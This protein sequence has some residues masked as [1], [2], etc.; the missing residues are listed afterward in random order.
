MQ[1]TQNAYL[2]TLE[3]LCEK[4]QDNRS[5]SSKREMWS[6]NESGWVATNIIQSLE[7]VIKKKYI[8]KLGER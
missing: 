7:N 4:Y 6:G 8:F 1:S 3:V 5:S 2:D